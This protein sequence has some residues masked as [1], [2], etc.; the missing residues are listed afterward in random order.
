MENIIIRKSLKKTPL[1]SVVIP[2]FNTEDILPLCLESI[3][4]NL[5]I[6][7]TEIVIVDDCSPGNSYESSK[8]LLDKFPNLVYIKKTENRGLFAARVSGFKHSNGKYVTTVDSDDELCNINWESLSRVLKG[9][10]CDIYAL[11][12]RVGHDK[13]TA[14]FDEA[15][16]PTHSV[17]LYSKNNVW[18]FFCKDRHWP[19]VSKFYS[20]R[21]INRF[22]ELFSFEI[23]Y[24]NISE[25]FLG[26]SILCLLADSFRFVRDQGYYFYRVSNSSITRS[27]WNKDKNKTMQM[28]E[29]YR[30][31]CSLFNKIAR[32][33]EISDLKIQQLNGVWSRILDW[34]AGDFINCL[35]EYPDVIDLLEETFPKNELAAAI[36][37]TGID[38]LVKV[39]KVRKDDTGFRF[40]KRI[41]F[42]MVCASGGGAETTTMNVARLLSQRGFEVV[43]V[44]E[45]WK[46]PY[47]SNVNGVEVRNFVGPQRLIRLAEFFKNKRIECVIFE[48]HWREESFLDMLWAK[49]LGLNVIA[50]EHNN[51]WF[52]FFI[53]KPQIFNLRQKVYE[54]LD[55]ITCLSEM[56]KNIWLQSGISTV[57][58]IPN[59]AYFDIVAPTKREK[60][61]VL[62]VGRLCEL[63]G[64]FILPSIIKRVSQKL[65]HVKFILCGKFQNEKI[66]ERFFREVSELNIG[67]NIDYRGFEKNMK[68]LYASCTCLILPSYVE[69]SPM[70]VGEARSFGLPVIMTDLKNV[71]NAD[72]GV[73]RVEK[74]D[75]DS[76]AESILTLLTN[77]ELASELSKN[78]PRGLDRWGEDNVLKSWKSFFEMLETTNKSKIRTKQEKSMNVFISSI[79]FY[80]KHVQGLRNNSNQAVE[81]AVPM[82]LTESQKTK[83]RRYD[84][85]NNF[86]SVMFPRG[87]RRRVLLLSVLKKIGKKI[88]SNY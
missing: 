49:Y 18:D 70:V 73:I 83:I 9:E 88:S 53:N 76:F 45:D 85:V 23:P 40:P 29:Q 79:D 30:K 72:E 1:I 24:I 63:K 11:E 64:V 36:A 65:P 12:I 84:K 19:L 28:L 43:V 82:Q 87:S 59:L 2:V 38:N 80:S 6:D 56:D 75:A 52:P 20:R 31:V 41:A 25:D 22:C 67:N 62:F 51:F 69:G 66:K 37:K 61:H 86:A 58:Y 17:I 42:S 8:E 39:L 5:Q 50:Q 34:H 47:V 15:H 48:D 46:A 4:N 26:Y 27:G 3:L 7:E 16:C 60:E 57:S 71:D 32:D 10:S 55:G 14:I 81:I 68:Q 21:I 13:T 35:P 54:H 74:L 33:A 44:T 78:A 77:S